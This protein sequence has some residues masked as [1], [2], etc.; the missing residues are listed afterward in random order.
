MIIELIGIVATLFILTSM[1]FKTNTT[2]GAIIMR[3]INLVGSAIFVVYGSLLPA[4]S[5]AILNAGL[6]I[7]NTFHLIR[8]IITIKKEKENSSKTTE[9][10]IEEDNQN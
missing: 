6:V 2:K 1:L 5:T 3:S 4:I 10:K 9:E 8:L 7:I